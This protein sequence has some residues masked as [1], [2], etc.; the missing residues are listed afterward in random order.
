MG[1]GTGTSPQRQMAESRARRKLRKM[2]NPSCNDIAQVLQEEDA[3]ESKMGERQL[4]EQLRQ[5][6]PGE[7][8]LAHRALLVLLAPAG[9]LGYL[10]DEPVGECS[11]LRL[12]IRKGDMTPE[13]A[14]HLLSLMNKVNEVVVPNLDRVSLRVDASGSGDPGRLVVA[15]AMHEL[16]VPEHDHLVVKT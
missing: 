8:G 11:D 13:E 9:T 1:V 6:D 10:P 12:S 14:A 7:N 16:H 4:Q 5:T 15:A 3:R 2:E